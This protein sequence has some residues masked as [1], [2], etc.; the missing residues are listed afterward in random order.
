MQKTLVQGRRNGGEQ[1]TIQKQVCSFSLP[2]VTKSS[3][4][5]DVAV[6]L[7]SKRLKATVSLLR[8]VVDI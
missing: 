4:A 8:V 1:T 2:L 6:Y 7:L 5:Q 3:D